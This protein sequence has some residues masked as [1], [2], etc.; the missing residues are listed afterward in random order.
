[1]KSFHYFCSVLTKTILLKDFSTNSQ[2]IPNTFRMGA[3]LFHM[4]SQTVTT[5]LF[6]FLQFFGMCLKT[7]KLFV[8]LREGSKIILHLTNLLSYLASNGIIG[9]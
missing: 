6:C 9:K 3:E 2:C 5:K 7:D 8:V 1:V 4:D